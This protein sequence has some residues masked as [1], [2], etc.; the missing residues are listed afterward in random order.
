MKHIVKSKTENQASNFVGRN[1]LDLIPKS[2]DPTLEASITSKDLK[3]TSDLS[4]G[5]CGGRPDIN[6]K[7]NRPLPA[8]LT[9]QL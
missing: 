6:M 8:K 1:S 5:V 3:T 2:M 4:G 7:P 9:L